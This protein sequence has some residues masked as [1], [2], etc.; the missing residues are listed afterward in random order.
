[1]QENPKISVVVPVYNV[2]VYLHRCVDSI[3]SQDFTDLELLLIDDGSIDHSGELCDEYAIYDSRVKVFH[4]NNEGVSSARNIGINNAK[5]EFIHFVDADDWIEKD[6]YSSIFSQQHMADITYISNVEHLEDG[7]TVTYSM[8]CIFCDSREEIEKAIL[9]L[10]DN[11]SKYPFFG[12]TWNKIFR[13]DIIKNNSL[14]FINDF[15]LFEDEIFTDIYC[16]YIKSINILSVP[17]YHYRRTS[18]GL[19]CK[20]RKVKHLLILVDNLIMIMDVYKLKQL[21]YYEQRRALNF[22]K[23]AMAED[24]D[25]H[26]FTQEKLYLKRI[27]DMNPSIEVGKKFRLV[28][29]CPYFVCKILF[30]VYYVITK[31]TFI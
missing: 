29:S 13:T 19:T 31:K 30:K 25:Q 3:L 2:E 26:Y 7:T 23:H 9:Y 24:L 8:P 14:N 10:K 5:G 28:N 21:V 4:Q 11:N 1:M 15:A 6:T 18:S 12:F 20:P 16:K 17:L 22:L 27:I